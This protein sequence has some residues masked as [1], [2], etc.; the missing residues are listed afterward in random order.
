MTCLQRLLTICLALLLP[1]L[2]HAQ[3]CD[4]QID[5][6]LSEAKFRTA[7]AEKLLCE[8]E[9][10]RPGYLEA[11]VELT[12]YYFK[13][14]ST[15]ACEILLAN[16]NARIELALQLQDKA[17]LSVDERDEL[18]NH[19]RAAWDMLS[20]ISYSWRQS[21]GA[22]EL[23]DG[24]D[25]GKGE[26]SSKPKS[27][28]KQAALNEAA[29]DRCV[30]PARELLGEYPSVTITVEPENIEGYEL[31]W[32]GTRR[33]SSLP[34][35]MPA[36]HHRLDI[37]PPRGHTTTVTIDGNLKKNAAEGEVTVYPTARYHD[38]VPIHQILIQFKPLV[39]GEAATATTTG[40]DDDFELDE[41]S[42]PGAFHPGWFWTGVGLATA[43]GIGLAVSLSS[44]AT[45]EERGNS[46]FDPAICPN[47]PTCPRE[48]IEDAFDS[49]DAW[50]FWGGGTSGVVMG[51]GV[52]SIVTSFF[53]SQEDD[54][55][56]RADDADG[57]GEKQKRE[58]EDDGWGDDGDW[59]RLYPIVS[60]TF[61]GVGVGGTF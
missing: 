48:D 39:V 55:D 13:N 16:A 6:R 47:G 37:V 22:E 18:R 60:P 57:D 12:D 61:A 17:V 35:I 33:T 21:T 36:A 15:P 32:N 59:G 8:M 25:D 53:V 10:Q 20:G 34:R 54:D 49:A 24:A 19:W 52:A 4:Q 23:A 28:N 1:T 38:P 46:L 50:R 40:A 11:V 9:R 27:A 51:L 42:G 44:A 43:G 3:E 30:R 5:A 56:D 58:P 45:H 14:S 41:D 2:A 7:V 26:K 31:R 29:F